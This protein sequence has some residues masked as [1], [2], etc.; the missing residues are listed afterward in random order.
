[1]Q[2]SINTSQQCHSLTSYL[3]I[4]E[5][6]V[7]ATSFALILTTAGL[8]ATGNVYAADKTAQSSQT[9]ATNDTVHSGYLHKR[10][11]LKHESRQ[12]N[13]AASVGNASDD[14]NKLGGYSLQD[15]AMEGLYGD[16]EYAD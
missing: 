9:L 15:G 5:L 16:G 14:N 1:M 8:L 7:M 6:K 13:D 12:S 3:K 11:K 10:D 4:F 2:S